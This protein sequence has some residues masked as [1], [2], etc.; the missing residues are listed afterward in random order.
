LPYIS[1]YLNSHPNPP[2]LG[3]GIL[4]TTIDYNLTQKIDTLAQNTISKLAWKD[5]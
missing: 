2:L 5:V 1:D 3:E 4:N